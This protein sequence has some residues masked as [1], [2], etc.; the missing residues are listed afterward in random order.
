[1]CFQARSSRGRLGEAAGGFSGWRAPGRCAGW[2]VQSLSHVR[3]GLEDP[4]SP[5]PAP[6]HCQTLTLCAPCCCLCLVP[7]GMRAPSSVSRAMQVS[8]TCRSSACTLCPKFSLCPNS[9]GSSQWGDEFHRQEHGSAVPHPASCKVALPCAGGNVT[10]KLHRVSC[11]PASHWFGTWR[12]LW[13]VLSIHW[14]SRASFSGSIMLRCA[15][16]AQELD[17]IVLVGSFQHREFHDSVLE[18]GCW[19]L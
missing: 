10:Q 8:S 9:K 6:F 17:S 7:S 3:L 15:V 12:H 11:K 4:P 18:L 14:P 13:D 16:Q 5:V 1:M 19:K 2:V